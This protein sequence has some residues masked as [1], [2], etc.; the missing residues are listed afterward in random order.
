MMVT[1]DFS[2]M[3]A[4]S[5]VNASNPIMIKVVINVESEERKERKVSSYA[6]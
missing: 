6:E 4:P 5:L 2:L 1:N 3:F